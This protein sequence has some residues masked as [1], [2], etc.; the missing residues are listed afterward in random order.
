MRS[1]RTITNSSVKLI[2]TTVFPAYAA[3]LPAKVFS[4]KEECGVWFSQSLLE[5]EASLLPSRLLWFAVHLDGFVLFLL[6]IT[7]I[8][9]VLIFRAF[10][11][12]GVLGPSFTH[13][14]GNLHLRFFFIPHPHFSSP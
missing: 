3:R 8:H 2:A 10:A 11:F 6:F 12:E 7:H 4:I 5:A 13:Q 1:S 9:Q 14:K